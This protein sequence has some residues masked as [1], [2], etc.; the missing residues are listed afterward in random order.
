[1]SRSNN[2]MPLRLREG[3]ERYAAG[4]ALPAHTGRYLRRRWHKQERRK[5]RNA[6]AAAQEPPPSRSRHSVIYDYW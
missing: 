3:W 6:L 4:F 2:T 5:A 1:M